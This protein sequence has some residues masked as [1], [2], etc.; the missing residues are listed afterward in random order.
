MRAA[1]RF[2]ASVWV[3]EEEEE[4]EEEVIRRTKGGNASLEGVAFHKQVMRL[5]S[6]RQSEKYGDEWLGGQIEEK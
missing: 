4:E 2:I 6:P 1:W 3:E 5:S